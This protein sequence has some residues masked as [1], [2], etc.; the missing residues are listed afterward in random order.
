LY[1]HGTYNLTER[2]ELG[3]GFRWSWEEKDASYAI[4]G[5][6]LPA[7]GLATGTFADKRTDED[8]SPT[9][10]LTYQWTP[11]L[12]SYLRYAEGY[13]SGG[14]NLDF[15]G[16]RV[17]PNGLEFE[18]E[19][20]TN[21]EAG[22]KGDLWQ[23]RFGFAVSVFRTE[24]DNYQVDQFLEVSPGVIAIVIGNAAE[25]RTQGIEI[26]ATL[27]PIDR[28]SLNIGVGLLEAEFESFPGGGTG[29]SD[30]S[31]KELPGAAPLQ[32]NAGVSYSIPLG[33]SYDLLLHADYAYRD[34]YF[35]DIDNRTSVSVGGVSVPYDR[36]GASD[37]VNARVAIAPQSQRWEFAL[38][39]RNLLDSQNISIYGGDFFG[40]L[41]RR[42]SAPRT[43]GAE[44]SAKF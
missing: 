38:W 43:W 2:L 35:S 37:F 39:S 20:A 44:I 29:N 15:V 6:R 34:R 10:T 25:V 28:L 41:T 17:F 9:A 18:R 32:A 4:D 40:T 26:E 42:Y 12:V 19:T 36:V 3:V 22:I 1:G 30:A 11:T 5:S 23:R 24:F 33:R 21:Y 16:P 8:F 27:R 13:K 31:G 14:Y 7:F